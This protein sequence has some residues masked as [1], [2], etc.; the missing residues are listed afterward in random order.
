M[1]KTK[2]VDLIKS[3]ARGQGA[4]YPTYSD[5]R[6]DLIALLD[7]PIPAEVL[8]VLGLMEI[9]K[10]PEARSYF[11]AGFV[12]KRHAESAGAPTSSTAYIRSPQ[13]YLADQC[14][15]AASARRAELLALVEKSPELRHL[16]VSPE[17]QADYAAR[18]KDQEER[19]AKWSNLSAI[20]LSH[21]QESDG[22][23]SALVTDT[24]GIAAKLGSLGYALAVTA[25]KLP[26][27]GK[28]TVPLIVPE[29]GQSRV[30]FAQASKIEEPTATETVA[31]ANN[32]KTKVA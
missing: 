17:V 31:P 23:I 5:D 20:G 3:F 9:A 10:K 30:Y 2:V 14:A 18:I 7:A 27:G 26:T 13:E 11:E 4:L 22:N 28:V 29:N 1:N 32:K 12:G 25:I 8:T 21:F 19:A 24:K 6:I 15:L 16:L